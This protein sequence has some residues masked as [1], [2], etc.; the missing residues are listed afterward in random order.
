[1]SILQIRV[2]IGVPQYL[3]ANLVPFP[4]LWSQIAI[5]IMHSTFPLGGA[6]FVGKLQ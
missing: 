2:A 6:R 3:W 1:M 5:F 4:R